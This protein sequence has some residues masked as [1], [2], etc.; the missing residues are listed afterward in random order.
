MK[1]TTTQKPWGKFE[2]YTLNEPTTVKIIYINKGESLSLQYHKN[3]SEFWKIIEGNPIVT[4]GTEKIQAQQND[5]F[6]IDNTVPH[7]IEA[8]NED[9]KFLEIAHGNFDESDIVRLEDK[10]GREN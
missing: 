5:E 2:Q 3:R 9:V 10:Y 8:T 4:I 6:T 7:R 1:T